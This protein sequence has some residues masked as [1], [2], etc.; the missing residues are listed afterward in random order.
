[1][2][3]RALKFARKLMRHSERGY[4]PKKLDGGKNSF[5]FL[6]E[7]YKCCILMGM[8]NI[9]SKCIFILSFVSFLCSCTEIIDTLITEY[10]SDDN[11]DLEDTAYIKTLTS[12]TSCTLNGVSGMTIMYA[13]FNT[14]SSS[15]ISTENQRYVS[16]ISGSVSSS[17]GADY[18]ENTFAGA[19]SIIEDYED[20]PATDFIT[21]F[22]SQ[23]SFVAHANNYSR[24]ATDASGDYSAKYNIGDTITV[25]V[26]ADVN[27]S[28][29]SQVSVTLRAQGT[30]SGGVIC[31]IWVPDANFTT[32]SSC[33]GSVNGSSAQYLADMFAAHYAHERA[34][35]G[36]ECEYLLTSSGYKS[37]YLERSTVNIVI[38]D[39]GND[40]VQGSSYT[41]CSGQE[42][43]VVGYFYAKD[44]FEG[45]TGVK[46]YSN[47]GKFFYI[48][49]AFCNYNGT[50]KVDGKTKY[51]YAGTGSASK[52]VSD[53]VVSTLF[54]EFQHMI[55][56]NNK[57]VKNSV[58]SPTW[59]NEMLSM[60][61]EDMMQSQL[62]L[63]DSEAPRGA[64]L[65]GFCKNYYKSGIDEYLKSNS[66]MSYYTSYAFG[67]WLSRE[68]GGPAFVKAMS[69]NSSVG[70][71]SIRAAITSTT[72][73][74]YSARQLLKL[75][76]QACAFRSS[77]AKTAGLPTMY[78][79]AGGEITEEGQTSTMTAINLH[80]Y[81]ITISGETFYGPF[82]MGNG[83]SSELRPHGFT[84]HVLGVAS[85]DNITLSFS[86][87]K[88]E[89]EHIIVFAQPAF[90]YS[91]PDTAQ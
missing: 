54:H 91:A 21:H 30:S 23:E 20:T 44:Y 86:S 61:A 27:L 67:A 88:D 55:L 2:R 49:A 90:S 42:C 76:V 12:E 38:Y 62:G 71:D 63:S 46:A 68:F 1:M 34:V 24:A 4:A 85:D 56:F 65:P 13:N 8:R 51:T 26:D 7:R 6:N 77:Y 81:G 41:N 70:M 89:N 84:L 31:N 43:G 10:S 28:T 37:S 74:T 59:Y 14:S 80:N 83:V 60:L 17:R 19:T 15:A 66:V 22:A 39:I 52:P 72:G 57:N 79:D 58:S 87:R 25:W 40:Y 53:T 29:Y 73:K 3:S 36:N 69:Q 32:G 9:C 78:K 16:R 5:H 47:K 75:F 82:L 18:T 11:R 35:F 64:R 45:G 33:G 50:T 48:D